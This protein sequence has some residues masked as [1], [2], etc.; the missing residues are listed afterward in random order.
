[1]VILLSFSGGLN[2]PSNSMTNA[3]SE[4]LNNLLNNPAF[5]FAFY[6]LMALSYVISLVIGLKVLTLKDRDIVK[7]IVADSFR[8]FV[9]VVIP[10][11][12][13]AGIIEGILISLV[14]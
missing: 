9:F 7:E 10:L 13:I 8:V 2:L 4:S 11:L 14:G 1:M 12:V 3:G 5:S 6:I